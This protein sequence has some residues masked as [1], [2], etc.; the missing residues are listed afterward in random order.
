[1]KH[2]APIPSVNN[3]G[4]SQVLSV[5]GPVEYN[6]CRCATCALRRRSHKPRLP[7]AHKTQVAADQALQL[8]SH[9]ALNF[10]NDSH[11]RWERTIEPWPVRLS[12]SGSHDAHKGISC[13]LESSQVRSSCNAAGQ[14]PRVLGRRPTDAHAQCLY[15][16]VWMLSGAQT[17]FLAP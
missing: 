10:L 15:S 16:G 17:R 1:M 4:P 8:D 6:L 5:Q 7:C 12:F 9:L 13:K 2:E 11:S 3:S 14:Q